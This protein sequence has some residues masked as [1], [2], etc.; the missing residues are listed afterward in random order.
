MAVVL[1]LSDIVD[2]APVEEVDALPSP[3]PQV[4]YQVLLAFLAPRNL[5]RS[6]CRGPAG[7]EPAKYL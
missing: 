3:F 6:I 7:R 2:D 1:D 4:S 5:D